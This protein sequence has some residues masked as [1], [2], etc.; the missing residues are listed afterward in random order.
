MLGDMI[1]NGDRLGQEID[2]AKPDIPRPFRRERLV[3][4]TG[5]EPSHA[6]AR[7]GRLPAEPMP[8][9]QCASTT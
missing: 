8:R 6:S 3:V 4:S 7:L 2:F 5:V 1:F 9:S